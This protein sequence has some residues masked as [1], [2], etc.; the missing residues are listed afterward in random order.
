MDS[1]NALDKWLVFL[2]TERRQSAHTIEAY[3]RDLRFFLEYIGDRDLSDLAIGEFRGFITTL[4]KADKSPATIARNISAI[5]S[6]F[7]FCSQNGLA[8]N[9]N[10]TLLRTP[11]LPKKLSSSLDKT[12]AFRLLDAFGEI[13]PEPWLAARD[14]ALFTLIYG[15]GLR[16]SEALNLDI[17][18]LDTDSLRVMGKGNKERIVPLLPIIKKEVE[19]Y[20]KL[21]PWHRNEGPLFLG[22]KGARLT[23]RVAERDL[24]AARNH[25]QLPAATTPH[26]LR[27][28][29]ATHLLAA[30][31]D[32]RTIQEL[33]GHS[34]LSTTQLYT[35]TDMGRIIA[36]YNKA[37]PHA[38]S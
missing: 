25:L 15:A 14:R 21:L 2:R 32:L 35:K 20:L 18:S 11:K 28:S 17:G 29:F 13:L 30:G 10:L 1:R 23:A 27:H 22:A 4:A 37:H 9:A 6:F 38:K 26:S 31:T 36:E 12:D 3:A 19:A 16:I 24:E 7:R 34:S 5:K 8:T 33:L